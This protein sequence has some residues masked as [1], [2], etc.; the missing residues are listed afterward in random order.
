MKEILKEK[1]QPEKYTEDSKSRELSLCLAASITWFIFGM[2][3]A[4]DWFADIAVRY[5]DTWIANIF[6]GYIIL[7]IA[8]IPG[9]IQI[10]H[11]TAVLFHKR[12][13]IT[14]DTQPPVTVL[15]AAYN[16]QA[17]IFKTIQ[18]I[19]DQ[20]YAGDIEILVMNDGSTDDTS[21]ELAKI[22]NKPNRSFVSFEKER[23]G[24]AAALNDLMKVAK[25]DLIITV[26]GDCQLHSNAIQNLVAKKLATGY[27]AIAGTVFVLNQKDSFWSRI[28]Y[29]EYCLGIYHVK[30]VQG[31]FGCTSVCQGAFS[32]YDK[33]AI[34]AVGGWKETV[35]EDIVLSWDMLA[36]KMKTGHCDTAICF[37]TVPTSVS[38]LMKQ[39][40]R[41]ARGMIEAIKS[42]PQ[43]AKPNK[44]FTIFNWMILTFPI[45]D[46]TYIFILLPSILLAVTLG[47][48]LIVGDFFYLVL[49]TGFTL[50][51][52]N[53]K[54]YSN[55]MKYLNLE[56]NPDRLGF[57]MYSTI[58]GFYIQACSLIGYWNELSAPS[59][60]N[61]GTK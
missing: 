18:S 29:W 33:S 27:A 25:Y 11:Y 6:T 17:G 8:L 36:N 34:L 3:F 55:T 13:E 28:Q 31:Y 10:F 7:F 59:K 24:K 15:V 53:Y 1:T 2:W 44:R 38:T 48:T 39:R 37:T 32:I 22:F 9:Y 52:A 4:T 61:W 58:Y 14:A 56:T 5:G 51:L 40:A 42:S 20:D 49:A 47:D 26:D 57:L 43:I 50:N 35:G 46:F 12:D 41:W 16:E 30:K 54:A 45:I 21:K 60:K 19:I 23:G